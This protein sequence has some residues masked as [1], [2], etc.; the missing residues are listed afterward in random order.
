[1]A[2]TLKDPGIK[3]SGMAKDLK[4]LAMGTGTQ[5]TISPGKSVELDT[6]FG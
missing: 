3:T 4:F 2:D 1:M 6:T 5:E